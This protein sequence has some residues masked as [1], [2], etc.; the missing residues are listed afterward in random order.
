MKDDSLRKYLYGNPNRKILVII[1]FFL[2]SFY[3][4]IKQNDPINL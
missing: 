3:D 1:R 4:C 2:L